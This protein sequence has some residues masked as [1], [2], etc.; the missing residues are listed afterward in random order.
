MPRISLLLVQYGHRSLLDLL[1]AMPQPARAAAC[2]PSDQEEE[3]LDWEQKSQR[4]NTLDPVKSDDRPILF[5]SGSYC[6]CGGRC[7]M[8]HHLRGRYRSTSSFSSFSMV[9][10]WRAHAT[11]LQAA[12]GPALTLALYPVCVLVLQGLDGGRRWPPV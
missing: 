7:P 9:A 4:L 8:P 1:H 10:D 5:Q 12:K 11:G 2:Q 3:L 6:G